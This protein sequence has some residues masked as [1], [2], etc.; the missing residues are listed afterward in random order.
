MER[1]FHDNDGGKEMKISIRIHEL[2]RR[3]NLF[4]FRETQTLFQAVAEPTQLPAVYFLCC[5]P[6]RPD[7]LRID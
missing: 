5:D 6:T 3:E 7:T 1:I 2:N 4:F